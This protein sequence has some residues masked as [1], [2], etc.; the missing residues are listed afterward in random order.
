MDRVVAYDLK[1]EL[2]TEAILAQEARGEIR[3]HLSSLG[4]LPSSGQKRRQTTEVLRLLF[5][6]TRPKMGLD[7]HMGLKKRKKKTLTVDLFHGFT[8]GVP[9]PLCF[10]TFVIAFRPGGLLPCVEGQHLYRLYDSSTTSSGAWGLAGAETKKSQQ[11]L[12]MLNTHF[13][14]FPR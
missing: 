14:Q 10:L 13:H 5:N 1:D 7:D 6:R 4:F 3:V 8:G 9:W 2:P 11:F 12:N